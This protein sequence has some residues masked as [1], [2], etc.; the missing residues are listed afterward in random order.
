MATTITAENAKQ[1]RKS[2]DIYV[3]MQVAGTAMITGRTVSGT[4]KSYDATL[5]E[6]AWNMRQLA[7]LSGD[8]FPLDG[9]A[10]WY[11]SSVTPSAN[12]GKL[13]L[14]G[15]VGG[16]VTVQITASSTLTAITIADNA[17]GTIS[18]GNVTY[19]ATG[20]DVVTINA[21]TATLVFTPADANSR[22]EIDYIVPG[23]TIN[24]TND[25]IVSCE[26]SLRSNL[27]I[28]DHTWEESDITVQLYYPNDIASSLVYVQKD[29]P[30]TY[31]AGYDS[32]LSEV[33]RFYLSEPIEWKD[34]LLTIKGV[35]AS[36][37]LNNLTIAEHNGNVYNDF[38]NAIRNAGISAQVY[39]SYG[40]YSGGTFV[41]PEMTARDYVA[42][43]MNLTMNHVQDSC[44]LQFVD[45]GIPRIEAGDGKHWGRTWQLNKSDLGDWSE[46]WEHNIATI[47]SSDSERNFN[48][49]YRVL[50]GV[51]YGGYVVAETVELDNITAGQICEY[52][53]DS[54]V[55]AAKTSRSSISIIS[56][57]PS[58][59]VVKI[60]SS[61]QAFYVLTRPYG[62]SGGA[63]QYANPNGL[64]GDVV[65][66]E[67]FVHGNPT[68]DVNYTIYSS[69]DYTSL[70]RR[71]LHNGSFTWKGDPRMQP[72]DY[73]EITD[74]VDGTGTI[75]ARVSSIS[76]KHSE[77]GTSAE[78]EWR[79][80]S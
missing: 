10:Q 27:E 17:N 47:K 62:R 34:N 52:N 37:R 4:Y 66:M 55:N 69:F 53:F 31:R 74:D 26:L 79:E 16:T 70:F 20:M 3:T 9:S 51:N 21:R 38:V 68:V 12:N 40:E 65:E 22:V 61:P 44:K 43:V 75:M 42:G 56:F 78:I 5:G 11:D 13:G 67:P 46:T 29:W 32:D 77:G 57:T 49:T 30:I 50:S 25:N 58:R 63:Q 71:P 54:E 72:L 33:R 73:L 59:L 45:A 64:P 36:S 24:A 7:D 14:R 15:N 23:L 39:G 80:W 1:F 60:P 41:T 8:G 48:E 18:V 28:T 2:M 76:L 35:D 19:A 6:T